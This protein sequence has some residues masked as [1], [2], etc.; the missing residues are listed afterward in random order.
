MM[1]HKLYGIGTQLLENTVVIIK[2]SGI[3]I[4]P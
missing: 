4:P 1:I 2:K 3:T